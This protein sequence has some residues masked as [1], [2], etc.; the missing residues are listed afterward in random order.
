[1][2]RSA[3]PHHVRTHVHAHLLASPA[4]LLHLWACDMFQRLMRY[5]LGAWVWLPA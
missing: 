1:M 5:Q 3:R 4:F 2:L